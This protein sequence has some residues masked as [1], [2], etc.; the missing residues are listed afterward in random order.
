MF[1]SYIIH[2]LG[3]IKLRLTE[4]V[5]VV[6]IL[7]FFSLFTNEG[8]TLDRRSYL[9]CNVVSLECSPEIQVCIRKLATVKENLEAALEI[10]W[11]HHNETQLFVSMV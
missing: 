8:T 9:C 2:S 6:G 5:T 4:V 3:T 7:C 10:P 11:R 1:F